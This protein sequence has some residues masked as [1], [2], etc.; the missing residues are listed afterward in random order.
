[1]WVS[2]L[3]FSSEKVLIKTMLK[4]NHGRPYEIKGFCLGFSITSCNFWGTHELDIDVYHF[5]G[6]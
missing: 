4:E 2:I 5:I 3:V 6:W 1:M